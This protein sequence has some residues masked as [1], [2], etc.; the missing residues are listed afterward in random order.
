MLAAE[1]MVDVA[2][3]KPAVSK[4]APVMLA[5]EVMV[6]VAEIKPAVSKLPPVTLAVALTSPP[7]KRFPPVMLAAEVIVLVAEI[8]PGVSRLPPVMLPVTFIASSTL[9]VKLRLPTCRLAR[10][11]MVMVVL[12]SAVDVK[13]VTNES[14]L[15][16]H[17]KAMLL[18]LPRK[19][20]KPMSTV[21]AP[22]VCV[23]AS[24]M[25][26][27]SMVVMVVSMAVLVPCTVRLPV[28]VRSDP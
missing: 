6:D 24:T 3:I 21:G 27:S 22:E 25:I 8:R 9:P 19:P 4:L 2:E 14:A 10:L 23:E 1:V 15:S 5:A 26:G 12:L 28:M 11:V 17:T 13:A 16:S 20:M 18:S 7:V